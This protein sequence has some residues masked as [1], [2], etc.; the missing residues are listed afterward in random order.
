ML[1]RPA[2]E[3]P[4]RIQV[5]N[6]GCKENERMGIESRVM[7]IKVYTTEKMN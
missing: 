2:L 5:S 1:K 6:I 7:G 3:H 4:A